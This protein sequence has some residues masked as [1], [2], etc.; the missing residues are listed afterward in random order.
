MNRGP[1]TIALLAGYLSLSTNRNGKRGWLAKMGGR[2]RERGASGILQG[3]E[4]VT[5]LLK[6]YF[7]A[8]RPSLG[9]FL[10]APVMM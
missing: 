9:E 6:T 4:Q 7:P 5:E 1:T 8:S 3:I 2:G 10:N